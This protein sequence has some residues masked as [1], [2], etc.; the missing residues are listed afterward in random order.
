MAWLYVA[1]HLAVD[2]QTVRID[3]CEVVIRQN[4][5]VPTVLHLLCE[6]AANIFLRATPITLM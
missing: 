3:V 4:P 5:L 1:K 2:T 6:H